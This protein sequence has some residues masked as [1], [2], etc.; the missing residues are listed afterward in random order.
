MP[1]LSDGTPVDIILNPIGVPS[2]MNLGQVLESHLG[3]AARNLNF[4]ALTPV[5]E[6]ADDDNIED[7]L[8]RW[9]FGQQANAAENGTDSDGAVDLDGVYDWLREQ[10]FDPEVIYDEG[11]Q[12]KAR[13]ACLYLWLRDVAGEE[14]RRIWRCFPGGDAPARAGR[15]S[16]KV[17]LPRPLSPSSS[18]TT[19]APG[20]PS[21][22]RWPW[23]ASICSN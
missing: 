10:G 1:F 19:D 16:P 2:R 13:E 5:F 21:T 11:Q 17:D 3:W 15:P 9:W 7:S 12:G 23:A 14:C 18:F 22:S 20:N 6:G 8:A 4:Q